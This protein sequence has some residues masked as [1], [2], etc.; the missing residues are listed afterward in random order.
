MNKPDPKHIVFHA[1]SVLTSTYSFATEVAGSPGFYEGKAILHFGRRQIATV[2][3]G[4]GAERAICLALIAAAQEGLSA[5]PA[6]FPDEHPDL[7]MG[8]KRTIVLPTSDGKTTHQIRIVGSSNC[9]EDEVQFWDR[10]GRLVGQFKFPKDEIP[11]GDGDA[12]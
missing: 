2:A 6:A 11:K 4:R 8:D 12:D 1:S 10:F 3:H 9:P 5:F 7:T